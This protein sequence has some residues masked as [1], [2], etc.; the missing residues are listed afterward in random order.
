M[1][2]ANLARPRH[3]KSSIFKKKI[4]NFWAAAD[5]V[6]LGLSRW[7]TISPHFLMRRRLKW[8]MKIGRQEV[9]EIVKKEQPPWSEGWRRCLRAVLVSLVSV[10]GRF[11]VM[12]YKGMTEKRSHLAP[13]DTTPFSY[14]LSLVIS[15][16]PKWL[17]FGST[18]CV[19]ETSFCWVVGC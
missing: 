16:N 11:V 17:R 15:T 3:G 9:V 10:C 14:P 5:I 2:P 18:F 6:D 1:P 12:S 19:F 4:D 13:R 7:L 8:P